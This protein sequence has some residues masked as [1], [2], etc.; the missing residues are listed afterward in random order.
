M[1]R[2]SLISAART[3]AR[4]TGV[5]SCLITTLAVH[6]APAAAQTPPPAQGA[7]NQELTAHVSGGAG[8]D[9]NVFGNSAVSNN[10]LP[11]TG[12]YALNDLGL[13]YTRAG[14][15]DISATAS[16]DVRLY[17]TD[18]SYSS[19]TFMGSGLVGGTIARRLRVAVALDAMRSSEYLF[20]IFP[21]MSYG[22]SVFGFPIPSL[23]DRIMPIDVITYDSTLST[24]YSLSASST[25][26]AEYGMTRSTF[27]VSRRRFDTR[28]FGGHYSYGFTKYASLRLGYTAQTAL[29]NKTINRRT[30][31]AG[32]AYSR[33]LSFSRR[34]KFSF[35]AN[36]VGVDDGL[37]TYATVGGLASLN[38]QFGRFWT[39]NADFDRG[40][41][42]ID[43]FSDPF[44]SNSVS[45]T[46]KGNI[47]RRVHFRASGAY[48]RGKIGL[49]RSI[50]QDYT[51]G[52][53]TVRTEF[54]LTR[55]LVTYGE[56]VYYRYRF[57]KLAPLPEGS[58]NQ[59]DRNGVSVGLELTIPIVERK[60]RV[61]S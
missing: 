2:L 57:N 47:G 39:L 10:T 4:L 40:V 26:S 53:S 44:L 45:A 16:S 55:H 7:S 1:M 9:K 56:Y 33:P 3:A 24:S 12:S 35:T 46:L 34:T 31:D 42:F 60:R 50:F 22:D 13:D 25:L 19:H 27:T 59:L 21:K 41:S 15:V 11:R 54:A 29:Y 58:P 51:S 17:Q 18:K 6:P 48:S 43:G 49:V 61:T 36:S 8:F 52:N 28:L 23:N 30:I 38:H 5:A 14:S 20:W 37:N 32:I